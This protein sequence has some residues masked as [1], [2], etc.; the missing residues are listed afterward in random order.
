ML[1]RLFDVTFS[2]TALIFLLPFFLIVGL[3]IKL[4]SRGPVF[5]RGVRVGKQGKLFRPYKFRTMV[6][7]AEK[8]GGST[9]AE[10]DPRITKVGRFL[11][12]YK[13]DEFPQ[14]INVLKGEMSFVGPRPELEEHVRCYNE[15][16]KVILSVKPGMTDY[17]CIKFI[18]LDKVVGKE[19]ADEV[20]I[21]KV[22]SEKNRLRVKY[23]KNHSF[24]EDLKIIIKSLFVIFKKWN[25]KN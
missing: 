23:A 14:L 24:L 20:Y 18:S 8:L 7:G 21:K 16:E 17:S 5:Y 13:I 11:R 22:R 10:D 12:K 4:G 1:K 25:T 3:V 2:F 9:T 6:D 15:E 19:N